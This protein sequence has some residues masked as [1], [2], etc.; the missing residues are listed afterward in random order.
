MDNPPSSLIDINGE[1]S[2]LLIVQ[3]IDPQCPM[4]RRREDGKRLYLLNNGNESRPPHQTDCLPSDIF[5]RDN[6][7]QEMDI[8]CSPGHVFRRER[9]VGG[10]IDP[11]TVIRQYL[12]YFILPLWMLVGLLDYLLHR[13]GRIEDTA[14]TKESMLHMLQLVE[15]GVPVMFGLIFEINALVF[16]VMIMGLILHQTTALWDVS[17]AQSRRSISPLEQHVHSFMEI[18]PIM[19]LAFVTVL[20]WDQFVALFGFGTQPARFGLYLKSDP[21]PSEYLI[22]LFAAIGVFVVLPY[23]EELRRCLRTSAS[24][25]L[26]QNIKQPEQPQQA[27]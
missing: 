23:T 15:T 19:A 12:L 11:A 26:R 3:D 22:S 2:T 24:R 7:P 8:G 25:Q 17:Y 6:Y 4:I 21:L 5:S 1:Q 9:T 14:G 13:R 18:L 10:M 27:A 16:L 20:Y